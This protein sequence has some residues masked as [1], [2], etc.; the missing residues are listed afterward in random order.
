[1]DRNSPS[2]HQLVGYYVQPKPTYGPTGV[3]L[4]N[5]YYNYP[6]LNRQLLFFAT[7]EF[8]Y[9]AKLI[10]YPILHDPFWP[11]ISIKLP[12]DILKFDGKQGEDPKNHVMTFHSWCYSNS[13]MDDSISLRLL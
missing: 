6:Q 3:A 9:L 11:T 10:N 1:M 13:L 7:L 5:Q 2:Y 8:Q 4:P 12:L